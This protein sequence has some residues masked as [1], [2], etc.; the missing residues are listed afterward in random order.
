MKPIIDREVYRKSTIKLF[1]RFPLLLI[2]ITCFSAFFIKVL[3]DV[4]QTGSIA[5]SFTPDSGANAFFQGVVAG[6]GIFYISRMTSERLLKNAY[7]LLELEEEGCFLP[8][9]SHKEWKDLAIGNLI[10]MNNRFYFQPDKQMKMTLDFDF[11]STNGFTVELSEPLKSFGLFLITGE[12]H[13]LVI[14]DQ[15]GHDA[16]RFIVSEVDQHREAISAAMASYETKV[17]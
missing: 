17:L 8:C 9:M 16:G 1:A 10:I 12:K 15:Q 13:M 2:L 5:N 7:N 11:P 6:V 4:I 14:K 3:L